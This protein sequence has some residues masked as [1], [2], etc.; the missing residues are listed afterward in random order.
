MYAKK[1]RGDVL[2]HVAE[3]NV[4]THGETQMPEAL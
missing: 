4:Y 2:N 1:L 3:Q